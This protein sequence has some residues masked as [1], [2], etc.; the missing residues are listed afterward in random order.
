MGDLKP[1]DPR[2]K[3]YSREEV[4]DFLTNKNAGAPKRFRPKT[5]EE[6][7]NELTTFQKENDRLKKSLSQQQSIAGANSD[8]KGS[9]SRV[10]DYGAESKSQPK[11]ESKATV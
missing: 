4:N 9:R 11:A 8:A 7:E 6:L 2:R 5:R 3:F 1:T 10:G